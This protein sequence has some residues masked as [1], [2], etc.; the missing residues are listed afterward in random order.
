VLL[1]EVDLVDFECVEL[2]FVLDLVDFVDDDL[3]DED[4]PELECPDELC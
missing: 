3:P 2:D 1:V 4:L